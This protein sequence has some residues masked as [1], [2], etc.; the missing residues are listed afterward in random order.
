MSLKLLLRSLC[1][2]QAYDRNARAQRPKLTEET[3]DAL[4]KVT[5]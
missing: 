4:R 5:A 3:S 1:V 2:I